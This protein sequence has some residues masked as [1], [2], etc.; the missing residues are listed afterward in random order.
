SASSLEDQ[1]K[2]LERKLTSQLAA[3]EQERSKFHQENGALKAAAKDLERKNAM[4]NDEL[5]REIQK[6]MDDQS[7]RSF[8]AFSINWSGR[9]HDVDL[10]I[11]DPKGQKFDFK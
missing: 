7:R 11:E 1:V 2:N 9:D 3:M 8:M 6:R 5:K 10:M 4:L